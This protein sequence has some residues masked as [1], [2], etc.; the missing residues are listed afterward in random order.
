MRQRPNAAIHYDDLLSNLQPFSAAI[1][2]LGVYRVSNNRQKI[3]RK[4]S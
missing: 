2:E 1:K 4:S 3:K